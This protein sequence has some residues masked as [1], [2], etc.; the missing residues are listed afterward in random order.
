MK[1]IHFVNEKMKDKGLTEAHAKVLQRLGFKSAKFIG[2]GSE[3]SAYQIAN[4]V[5]KISNFKK[6]YF[7]ASFI[8][9]D[10]EILKGKYKHAAKIIELDE[11]EDYQYSIKEYVG[12][13]Q[14]S[15]KYLI[16]MQVMTN[17]EITG[18]IDDKEDMLSILFRYSKHIPKIK[19]LSQVYDMF[20]E[21]IKLGSKTGIE[22]D[23]SFG[24]V[25]VRDGI[26]KFFDI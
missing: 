8:N 17:S 3:G 20:E 14:D 5:V 22:I 4:V 18:K 16:E 24:N 10:K 1:I 12:K 23:M 13:I 26:I 21:A 15:L 6:S 9:V 7:E 2:S 25:G 11:V 19:E